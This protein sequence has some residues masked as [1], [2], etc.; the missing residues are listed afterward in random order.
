MGASGGRPTMQDLLQRRKR[1]A[2]IGRDAER[3]LFRANFDL[4][5][6]DDRHRF[7]FHVRGTAGVGKTSLVHQWEQTARDRAALT[8]YVDDTV[9]S[10]PEAM[11]AISAAFAQQGVVL[12]NL[13]RQLATYRQR[14]HEAESALA[15]PA[16]QDEP[17][18]AP[19]GPGPAP[20]P[21][22]TLLARLLLAGGGALPGAG[23]FVGALDPVQ[24]A[25]QADQLRRVLSSRFRNQ[26]DVQLVLDPVRALTP[27]FVAELERACAAAPWIALFFDTYERT[28]PFLDPWLLSLYTAR[29]HGGLPLNAVVTLAGQSRLDAA[30]WGD[31]AELVTDLPLGE[32]TEDE[33]RAL[34]AA[35]GVRDEPV[36]QDVLRLSGRLPVL[37]STLAE[38]PGDPHAPSATAVDRFLKRVPEPAHRAAA[39]ACALPRRLDA[40]VFD[41][42]SPENPGLYDWL[43]AL[44]FVSVRGGRAQYHAVVRGPMLHLSRTRSPRGWRAAHTRLAAAYE[45]WGAADDATYHRLCA[46]PAGA[47][48]DALRAGVAACDG[49]TARARRWARTLAEAGDDADD[50]ALRRWG[51]QCLTA[52]GE[53][54]GDGL[55]RVL[56][57]LLARG[58]LA[59]A[60]RVRALLVRSRRHRAAKRHRDSAADCERALELDPESWEAYVAR[61]V[62][63]RYATE[64]EGALADLARA[65]ELSGGRQASVAGELGETYR[66]AGRLEEALAALDRAHALDPSE[67][68]VLG[69]RATTKAALGRTDEALADA[70]LA[71][72]I[73]PEYRFGLYHRARILRGSGDFEGALRDVRS[74]L[75][76][77]PDDAWFVSE[78]GETYRFAGRY[79]EAVAAYD[80][81][82]ALDPEY[83]WAYGSRA[84]ARHALGRTDEAL[85]DLDRALE[86]RPGYRWAA[87]RKAEVLEERGDFDGVLAVWDALVAA[88]PDG[89][90]PRIRR[91][92]ALHRLDRFEEALADLG[93]VPDDDPESDRALSLTM[94]VHTSLGRL[95]EALA[96]WDRTAG[97]RSGAR[98]R[99]TRW[100]HAYVLL[101]VDRPAEALAALPEDPDPNTLALALRRAGRLAE[102]EAV[103]CGALQRAL[104]LRRTGR[105]TPELWREAARAADE[106][107]S[108]DLL[109]AACA[110]ADW[111]RADAL[112]DDLLASP[113]W[114]GRKEAAQYLAELLACP[115]PDREAIEPRLRK[116]TETLN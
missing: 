92:T 47:L 46:D 91:S 25:A 87:L 97:T 68:V 44:P 73:D 38:N 34:L 42:A 10:A 40:D 6:E 93:R 36:V 58:R 30:R 94:L 86:L 84:M 115:D 16:P 14:R 19:A 61:G 113:R 1:A 74:A 48:P 3:A 90:W 52:L 81:A 26:E 96:V 111:P 88:D 9:A 98:D 54:E 100:L 22:A 55:V 79:E 4:P 7:V 20:S 103:E 106:D 80:R 70:D 45:E 18:E 28:A 60:D 114:T 24:L 101:L 89:A 23:P 43:C 69:S 109:T 29:D 32:F 112:V 56:G 39:L 76:R 72:E 78:L 67:A 51:A 2:F 66:L 75:E 59:D 95:E 102:A 21:G 5:P 64:Y 53:E 83:A 35:R 17:Q 104:T 12:K 99:P 116:L 13:D 63:R 11:A 107:E 71:L 77:D 31:W 105:D 108:D 82:I 50:A 85:A 33:A 110:L 57:L 65:E 49:G 37:V 41:V 15:A 27:V 62:A 8:A